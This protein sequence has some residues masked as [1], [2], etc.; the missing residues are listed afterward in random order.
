MQDI[1]SKAHKWLRENAADYET[2][3]GPLSLSILDDCADE[4]G[5]DL[6]EKYWKPTHWLYRLGRRVECDYFSI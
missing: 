4:I 6:T 2:A 1:K 3:N 5:L